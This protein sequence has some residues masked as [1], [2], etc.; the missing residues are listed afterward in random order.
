MMRV[1]KLGAVTT[2]FHEELVYE[3]SSDLRHVDGVRGLRGAE[4]LQQIEVENSDHVLLNSLKIVDEN[5]G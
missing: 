1:T 2:F 4:R 5:L 3:I